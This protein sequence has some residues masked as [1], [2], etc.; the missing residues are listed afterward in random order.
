[1]TTDQ[2]DFDIEKLSK[3]LQVQVA[4]FKPIESIEKF[5]VGQSNPT[6]RF[7]TAD[8]TF[9]LRRQPFGKLLKSAHQVDREFRV[10]SSLPPPR[11]VAL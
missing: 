2:I 9:V 8:G 5:S 11:G 7:D 3:Y 10:M 6:Y 4:D 1:M